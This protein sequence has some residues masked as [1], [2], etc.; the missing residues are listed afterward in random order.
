[1]LRKIKGLY[2]FSKILKNYQIF[3]MIIIVSLFKKL[4]QEK[5]KKSLNQFNGFT[6]SSRKKEKILRYKSFKILM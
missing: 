4:K 5:P 2:R 3:K 6:K 1:M